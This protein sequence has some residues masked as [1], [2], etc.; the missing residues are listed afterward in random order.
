MICWL[1]RP[2]ENGYMPTRFNLRSRGVPCQVDCVL[3]GSEVEDNL[4]FTLCSSCPRK[5][6]NLWYEVEHYQR[7][8]EIFSN[9]IFSIFICL[10]EASCARFAAILWSIWQYEV[11]I[12]QSTNGL[13]Q[14]LFVNLQWTWSTIT[15]GAA[16][17]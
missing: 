17:W 16:T 6:S 12:F 2:R 5:E 9:I 15:I 4:C 1:I 8:S 13:F 10:N 3:F 14:L 11:S 7:Q